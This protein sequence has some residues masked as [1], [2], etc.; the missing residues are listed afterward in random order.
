M[1][2]L[3]DIRI[4]KAVASI[5]GIVM[6]ASYF[7]VFESVRS[8]ASEFTSWATVVAYFA[9][10]L[11]TLNLLAFHVNRIR[12]RERN[13]WPFSAWLVFVLLAVLAVGL[14]QGFPSPFYSEMYRVVYQPL[15]GTI[16]GLLGFYI[17]S[18]SYRA[19]R[20]RSL[21]SVLLLIG[22]AFVMLMNAPI[23]GAVW[24]GFPMIGDFLY[25]KVTAAANRAVIMGI[26]TGT[27]VLALRILIG[28]EAR[29]LGGA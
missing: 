29:Y 25:G 9:L 12:K 1:A 24:G 21:D 18:A 28:R 17:V 20:V 26:A 8:I 15:D 27:I 14:T 23:G 22:A 13:V 3:R 4:A 5:C 11:G 19:F 16:F 7:F 10:V 6:V 2:D